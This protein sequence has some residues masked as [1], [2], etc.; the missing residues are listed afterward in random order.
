MPAKPRGDGAAQQA[1]EDGLGLIVGVMA[2]GERRAV[3]GL[4]DSLE[5]VVT[6]L[7]GVF[8]ERASG[9]ERL[10]GHGPGLDMK[11]H[12]ELAGHFANECGVGGA[13]ALTRLVVEMNDL[14]GIAQ[15]VEDIEETDR[16]GSAGHRDEHEGGIVEHRVTGDG[17]FYLCDEHF[18]DT[19][20]KT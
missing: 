10:L 18:S 11:W 6:D 15:F 20:Q 12:L 8:F 5:K 17:V 2:C 4:G 19:V 13:G 9:I 14:E 1:H 3:A 16:V 7:A